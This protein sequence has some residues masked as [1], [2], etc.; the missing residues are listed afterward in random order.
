M[1]QVLRH[2]STDGHFAEQNKQPMRSHASTARSYNQLSN[3]ATTLSDG[4][5]AVKWSRGELRMTDF[6]LTG[7][8]IDVLKSVHQSHDEKKF[9]ERFVAIMNE[10]Q[11]KG[12]NVY[13]PAFG[14]EE[15][16]EA[17]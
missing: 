16:W 12:G 8:L 15:Y 5:H 9:R 4:G 10:L 17:M 3:S 13:A 1:L 14:S 2:G 6:G 11:T 7:K